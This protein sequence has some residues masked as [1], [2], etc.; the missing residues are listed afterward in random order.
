VQRDG[1]TYR[2]QVIGKESVEPED[3]SVIRPVQDSQ[4]TLIT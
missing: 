3:I 4:L 2:Y 1:K